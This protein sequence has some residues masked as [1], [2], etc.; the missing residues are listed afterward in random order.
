MIIRPMINTPVLKKIISGGQTGA[1]KGA[2]RAGVLL[3]LS[4][5]GTVPCDFETID[6]K[7]PELGEKYGCVPLPREFRDVSVA[8][9]YIERSKR[10]VDDSDGTIAFRDHPSPG[11]DKTIG[12]AVTKEWKVVDP[13]K[14]S[15]QPYKPVLVIHCFKDSDLPMVA[16]QIH[17]FVEENSIEVLNVCGNRCAKNYVRKMTK[18]ETIVENDMEYYVIHAITTAFRMLN[19]PTSEK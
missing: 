6:G 12:Y 1:D 3:G 9:M 13:T 5:G 8:R 2:L 4:T 18:K 11:T 10:N 16:K 14:W 19:P 15:G 7:C 17:S